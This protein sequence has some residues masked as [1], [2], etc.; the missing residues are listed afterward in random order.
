MLFR[1]FAKAAGARVIVTSRSEDKRQKAKE[2]GAD[3]AIDT[4]SDWEKELANET[5]DLVIDSVGR[6]TFNRSLEVVKRSGTMVV[7]GATTEDTVDLNI[8]KFFYKQVKLLGSTMGSK[9]EL[10]ALLAFMKKHEIHPIVGHTYN[11]EDV[12]EA[13]SFLKEN[14]Q[15]GKIAIQIN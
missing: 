5:I 6:A 7:F 14:N 10:Q 11:L 12:A 1:S 8:R 15:F 3:L 4:A 2:I 13:F 9:E